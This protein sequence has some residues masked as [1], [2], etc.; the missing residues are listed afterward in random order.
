MIVW[1]GNSG[2]GT[3]SDGAGYGDDF[4]SAVGTHT[5]PESRWVR[6][7]YFFPPAGN[8]MGTRYFTTA[9]ILGCE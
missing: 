3:Q 7:G 9:M 6:G 8:P 2:M 4:L 1:N 5:R